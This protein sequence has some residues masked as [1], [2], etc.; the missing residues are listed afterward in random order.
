M[1]VLLTRPPPGF[2]VLPHVF[3]SP[4]ALETALAVKKGRA[5]SVFY[6]VSTPLC[7]HL[8]GQICDMPG[9][10]FGL[11]RQFFDLPGGELYVCAADVL[12]CQAS[13]EVLIYPLV[14]PLLGGNR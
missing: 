2:A 4:A 13:H 11:L 9:Q 8:S 6:Y 10:S 12:G 3:A 1:C 7:S 5:L 14:F